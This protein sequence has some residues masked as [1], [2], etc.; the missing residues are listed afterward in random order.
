[1]P[2]ELLAAPWVQGIP[3]STDRMSSNV[4]HAAESD[5]VLALILIAWQ[6][7]AL[8]MNSSG[9]RA[10]TLSTVKKMKLGKGNESLWLFGGWLL[11]GLQSVFEADEVK[12]LLMQVRPWCGKYGP[13]LQSSHHHKAYLSPFFIILDGFIFVYCYHSS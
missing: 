8:R 2:L 5:M 13:T 7:P 12:R 6:T 9:K 4:V 10:A 1:M 11:C 3:A